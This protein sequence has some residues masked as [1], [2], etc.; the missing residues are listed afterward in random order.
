MIMMYFYRMY[1]IFKKPFK[2]LRQIIV[3][4]EELLKIVLP[5][6]KPLFSLPAK[7]WC[8]DFFV[9]LR[10]NSSGMSIITQAL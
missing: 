4:P 5:S 3:A 1:Y 10:W 7:H 6:K 8:H 2:K 9:P